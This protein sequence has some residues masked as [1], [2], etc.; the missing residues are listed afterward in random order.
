MHSFGSRVWVKDS[1]DNLKLE[2]IEF[3]EKSRKVS[4]KDFL[5]KYQGNLGRNPWKNPAEIH[6]GIPSEIPV[7]FIK[8]TLGGIPEGNL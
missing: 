4:L 1:W 8:V 6:Y 7:G 3:P 2:R 5:E